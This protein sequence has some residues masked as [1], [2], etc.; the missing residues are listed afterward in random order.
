AT[1]LVPSLDN[2]LTYSANFTNPFPGGF[3]PPP[4]ASG[5]LATNLGQG[6]TFFD[7]NTTS[8]YMQ[9]WQLA[10]QRQLLKDTLIEVSY[11]GN[12]GTRMQVTRDLNPTPAQYLSTSPFREQATIDFLS[13]QV[14]NPFFRLLPKTNLAAS[15]IARSQ[16]LKP[17]PQ[18]SGISSA[19][20]V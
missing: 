18:F 1:D 13:A 10:V 16:L 19:Q 11:V 2:G 7:P 20:N 15:T 12:R 17:Y 5:G 14:P 6:I 9:R 8:S 4:R 3:L